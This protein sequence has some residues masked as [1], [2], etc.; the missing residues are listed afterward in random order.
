[1]KFHLIITET[2]Q[3]AI[4]IEAANADEAIETGRRNYYNVADG[5]I[6]TAEDFCGAEFSAIRADDK[7]TEDA[8]Q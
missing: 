1:M 3:K 4:E 6:L 8:N 7:T 5:Y 2:L